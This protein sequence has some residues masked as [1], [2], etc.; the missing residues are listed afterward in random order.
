MDNWV[1]RRT[2]TGYEQA[3]DLLANPNNWRI[4]PDVQKQSLKGSLDSIGWMGAVKVNVTTGHVIDGHLRAMIALRKGDETPVPVDYYELSEDEEKVS[5]ASYDLIT[6]AAVRDDDMLTALIDQIEMD[7]PEGLDELLSELIKSD[8]HDGDDYELDDVDL[9]DSMVEI[10]VS[11]SRD[12]A[13]N[14]VDLVSD[15]LSDVEHKVEI[16]D[17]WLLRQWLDSIQYQ[18]LAQD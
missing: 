13:I 5:L 11:V 12:D 16:R 14:V 3:S 18:A 17:H 2:G 10:V 1:D 6:E 9:D 4:H 7:M 15:A 8:A